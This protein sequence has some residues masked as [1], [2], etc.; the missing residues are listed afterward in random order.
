MSTEKK[1]FHFLQAVYFASATYIN[2]FKI[3]FLLP[4]AWAAILL[5]TLIPLGILTLLLLSEPLTLLG[6]LIS[7]NILEAGSS[8]LLD[9]TSYISLPFSF[10]YA[11]SLILFLFFFFI[12][13][14]M[15]EYQL[16]RLSMSLY[17]GSSL[18]FRQLFSLSEGTLPSYMV[19]RIIYGL[20]VILGLIL[21]IVP[22]IYWACKYFFA[23][24]SLV[25]K[26]S[27]T[28]KEDTALSLKL[29]SSVMWQL[30][31]VLILISLS[32]S[33]AIVYLFLLRPIVVL[34]ETYLYFSLKS[35]ETETHP[36]SSL[37]VP[38]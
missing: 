1:P 22:G 3:F 23:G 15:Y 30:L 14:F 17:T 4:F 16:I 20:R 32:M 27:I 21:F 35:F 13:Y 38:R 36:D 2:N 10:L 37:S 29:S 25:E 19:A 34:T 26:S 28:I 12:Y 24:F 6:S 5:I 33:V 8:A 9:M 18:T 31:F 7:R 11:G